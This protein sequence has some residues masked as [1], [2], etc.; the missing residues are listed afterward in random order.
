[1]CTPT[2]LWK[3]SLYRLFCAD[4]DGGLSFIFFNTNIKWLKVCEYFLSGLVKRH[5]LL[6]YIV[7]ICLHCLNI[8]AESVRLEV[9]CFC[10]S[11]FA[12]L[13]S[14]PQ[15]L[16]LSTS[17]SPP[18]TPCYLLSHHLNPYYFTPSP[19]NS[20]GLVIYAAQFWTSHPLSEYIL[21]GPH[22]SSRDDQCLR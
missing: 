3:C 6:W 1:M 4:A 14:E 11:P 21:P 7:Q 16:A 2:C 20:C 22:K 8:V 13:P 17:N 15:I 5:D 9:S 19:L 12:F 10:P 18:F